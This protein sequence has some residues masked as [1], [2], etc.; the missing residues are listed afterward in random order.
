LA[1]KILLVDDHEV[2]RR[3][4]R[5]LLHGPA[6]W[7]VCGEAENGQQAIEKVF[8]LRPDLVI[9]DI[10]MPVMNGIEAARRIHSSAPDVKIVMFSMHDSPQ[11]AQQ[12][13]EAGASA[14]L[15]KSSAASDLQKTVARLL[16]PATIAGSDEQSVNRAAEQL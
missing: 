1:Y 13:A 9:L 10:S 8:E 15:L 16:R 6:D 3:G 7:D 12:A 2:V 4:V 14:C 11:I 5:T